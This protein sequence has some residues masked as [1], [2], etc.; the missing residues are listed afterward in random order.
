MNCK[1]LDRINERLKE[2][3]LRLADGNFTHTFPD[4]EV[5]LLIKT[6]P[7]AKA[8][9]AKATPSIIASYCPFCGKKQKPTLNDE[10][11]PANEALGGGE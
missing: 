1:C 11:E 10:V 2:Q 7:L 5:R 4:F 9:R 3:G 8:R 6:Q